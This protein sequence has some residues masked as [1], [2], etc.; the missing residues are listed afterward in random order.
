MQS[1]YAP[2]VTSSPTKPRV[3]VYIDYRFRET[4]HGRSVERAFALFLFGL[5]PHVG[6]LTLIGRLDPAQDPYHYAV[7]PSVAVVG[8]P[9]YASLAQ[10]AAAGAAIARGARRAWRALDDVDV[11]W[12]FGPNPMSVL[13]AV[14]GLVRRKRVV[15]GVRQDSRG[16]VR[17]RHPNRP[18]LH[19]AAALLHGAYRLLS[20]RCPVTVVG[21]ELAGQFRGADA[22]TFVVSLVRES[23]VRPP[24][25]GRG[26]GRRIL[27]VGRLDA[28]KNPLLLLEVM[29]L[30]RP[31]DGAPWRLDVVGGGP[32]ESELRTEVERRGLQDAV[33]IHGYLP[34]DDG[35]TEA[36]RSADAFLHVSWTEGMP[37]V[38]IE[39]FA[40]GLPTVATAVG[41]VAAFAG[42]AALLVPPGDA[43]AAAD[44]LR[45][46][47]RDETLRASLTR[48]GTQ[49]ARVHT[50]EAEAGRVAAF[51]TGGPS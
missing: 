39:S 45:R 14:M 35:L 48:R 21:D 11:L 6:T 26:F 16:Y 2:N 37:Q 18:G 47:D 30:L 12:S 20:R 7:P 3:G 23:D 10:P 32:L 46:L 19:L 4:G 49:I 31:D 28:E 13:I 38:L 50:L 5:E 33:R 42:D 1:H 36:Y 29:E 24:G 22:L 40:A 9:F 15:L 44:A 17:S 51:V 43:A 8:L 27:T 34:L 25:A 41:G